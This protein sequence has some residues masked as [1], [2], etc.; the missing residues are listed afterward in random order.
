[1]KGNAG[2]EVSGIE[3]SSREEKDVGREAD[4][5]GFTGWTG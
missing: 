5:L 3:A 1:M 2:F 4:S